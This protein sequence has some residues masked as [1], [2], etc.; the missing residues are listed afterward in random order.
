MDF[1][2]VK[3]KYP[4]S[5]SKY[6]IEKE[7]TNPDKFWPHKFEEVLDVFQIM[8]KW[9]YELE[10]EDYRNW[11]NLFQQE[12]NQIEWFR[13][14]LINYFNQILNFKLEWNP[15]YTKQQIVSQINTLYQNTFYIIDNIIT[16]LKTKEFLNK[17]NS[18]EQQKILSEL[19]KELQDAKKANEDISKINQEL[20]KS[21]E[22]AKKWTKEAS[23]KK[24]Q[25]WSIQVAKF[26]ETQYKEHKNNSIGIEE[27]EKD[28][29]WMWKRTKFYSWILLII[30]TNL[31]LY[32]ILW[33]LQK[34]DLVFTPEYWI[35]M[36]S[37]LII[38]YFWLFFST[39]NYYVEKDLEI[40]NKNRANIANTL[41]LFL[42]SQ[43]RDEDKSVIL[44]HAIRELFADL[45]GSYSS[46]SDTSEKLPIT[47]IT[48]IISN[49]K[50]L[51]IND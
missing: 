2:K 12:I 18:K 8:S 34:L 16:K 36:L 25:T 10:L 45:K 6:D 27:D 22:E 30:I 28:K 50:N 46:N 3:E 1:N 35:L 11:W 42:S 38:L 13:N 41:E 24:T 20:S 39:K 48:K 23:E 40:E 31:V 47:E 14:N 32:I 15:Q 49:G 33:W 51:K 37:L 19:K 29:W 7:L 4:D 43:Y 17:P 44:Q 9:V 5:L 21:L 26:F